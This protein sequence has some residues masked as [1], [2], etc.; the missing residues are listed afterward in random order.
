MFYKMKIVRALHVYK[1]QGAKVFFQKVST[2]L[3]R[4][5]K[6]VT[7]AARESVHSYRE[8]SQ[9]N[10]ISN[11]NAVDK[12]T[13]AFTI[14]SKNYMH[15]ALA[16]RE[17]FLKHNP[18]CQ[19]LIIL[20]DIIE[21]EEELDVFRGLLT[22][23]VE[24]ICFNEINNG[25]SRLTDFVEMLTKYTILEMNT[26][27]KP[28]VI[29]Y[30]FNQ[31]YRKVLYIDPDIAFYS[32]IAVLDEEL[33][34][35][36]IV[37]TPH[38]RMPYNDDKNP[39]E[40]DIMMGGTYNLG[41]IALKNTENSIRMVK[42]W[43]DRLFDRGFSDITKGLFTDQKWIDLVPSLFDK[44][45]VFKNAGYNVAYW[46]MHERSLEYTDKWMV[47]DDELVFFHFS[48]LNLN[49]L[50]PISKH[51]NRF[52]LSNFPHLLGLF[53]E[54]RDLVRKFA[55][56]LFKD[57]S[58]FYS[59]CAA[60][61]VKFPDEIRR[62]L[63]PDILK[64]IGNPFVACCNT[65]KKLLQ[66]FSE[67]LYGDS[68]VSRLANKIWEKRPDLMAVFP[69]LD[70][71]KS[72]RDQFSNWFIS[73]A[74]KDYSFSDELIKINYCAESCV[75]S[76]LGINLIGYFETV[77]G[78]A[79]ASRLFANKMSSSGISSALFSIES[80]AHDKLSNSEIAQFSSLYAEN[81]NY[82]SNIFFV[83]ANE[84]GNVQMYYPHLFKNKYNMAVWWWEFDDYFEYPKNI[85]Y[86][87]E[88]IVFTD[89]VKCAIE[90]SAP[91]DVK[92]TKK[93]Y[94]FVE[95]WNLV[96]SKSQIRAEYDLK[97]TDFV[98]IYV[99]DL[100][101]GYER[102]N[103]IDLINAFAK[104]VTKNKNA[105][106][107]LKIGHSSEFSKESKEILTLI[108]NKKIKKN[109]VL[110]TTP[111]SRN[112]LMSLVDSADVYVSL[113]RSEGLGLG[114]LEAMFLGK[115]TIATG[116]GGNLEFMNKE[117]SYLVDYELT[118]IENDFG[119]YKK[120][121]LWARPSVTHAAALMNAA[122]ADKEATTSMGLA[123]QSAV[124]KQFDQKEF[125]IELYDIVS[126]NRNV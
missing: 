119:P 64:H 57:F 123:G 40:V 33:S 11:A 45:K 28:Y 75:P 5:F 93:T 104:V 126:S 80:S 88:I 54:Y 3:K 108:D 121:W 97:D 77:T 113:H 15:Y 118:P 59:K 83:N 67:D 56:D 71:N 34:D 65:Q 89:F 66:Y 60:T 72:S 41:F 58:Y 74:K 6:N 18:D 116:Y 39:S 100:Y 50:K 55:P 48:G 19:F 101:S 79:E 78:V 70:S 38:I 25:I 42:W 105:K 107:V 20:M 125:T 69:D 106:L 84:I 7:S 62:D 86:I 51:Q 63:F 61:K 94:P 43:Q 17:S 16:L 13:I 90:K 98:F 9:L 47:N 114:M 96:G 103:P 1:N 8:L 37:L 109:V 4:S 82:N 23:G 10:I 76:S 112:D 68:K 122:I 111:L 87:N 91:A 102:K 124:M 32:N 46:N 81:P 12:N 31:G 27:M 99:F 35:F 29:E 52:T 115:P 117:N 14:V 30:L 110:I 22:E 49:D 95:N 36:D 120:G 85:E 24:F 53:K 26:G 92:V 73:S 21:T 44:V 2:H